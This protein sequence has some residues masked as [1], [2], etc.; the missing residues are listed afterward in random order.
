MCYN[1]H[2]LRTVYK[3][4]EEIL[5]RSQFGRVYNCYKLDN[6]AE[7]QVQIFPKSYLYEMAE[8][9]RRR[10]IK[11]FRDEMDIIRILSDKNIAKIVDICEDKLYFYWVFESLKGELL[12]D[13]ILKRKYFNER[14]C[15]MIFN[16]L[17]RQIYAMK[18]DEDIV[19]CNINPFYNIQ[20]KD[21]K[22]YSYIKAT[23]VSCFIRTFINNIIINI[24][25]CTI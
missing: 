19:H 13:Y 5:N 8:M 7:C 20:F 21:T 23:F 6:N 16:Q 2:D 10:I 14:D 22:E 1:I 17:L 3:T 12:F 11:Q 15:A 24:Y 25:V 4:T 9:Y 18:N